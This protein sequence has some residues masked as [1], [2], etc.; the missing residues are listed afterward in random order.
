MNRIIPSI[1]L[2][3]INPVVLASN[4]DQVNYGYRKWRRY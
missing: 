4:V 3:S 2:L 1:T